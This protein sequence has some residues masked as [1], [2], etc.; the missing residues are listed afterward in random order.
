MQELA[1]VSEEFTSADV[2]SHYS[3]VQRVL[4][5]FHQQVLCEHV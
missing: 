1:T 5:S 4:D 2:E 3:V